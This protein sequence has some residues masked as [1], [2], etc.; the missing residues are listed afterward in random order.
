MRCPQEK[1]PGDGGQLADQRKA[2]NWRLIKASN[3]S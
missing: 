1:L 2:N 3:V